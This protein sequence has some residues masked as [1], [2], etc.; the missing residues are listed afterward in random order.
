M[1]DRLVVV[2]DDVNSKLYYVIRMQ[3][4]GFRLNTFSRQAFAIDKS[5]IGRL[6]IANENLVRTNT[7]VSNG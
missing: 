5:T 1:Y 3:L 2:G 6:D 4:K 7:K